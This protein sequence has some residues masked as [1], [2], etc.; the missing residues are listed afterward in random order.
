MKKFY[1]TPKQMC[2]LYIYISSKVNNIT[3]TG[4]WKNG[5]K[6]VIES[7][8][9]ITKIYWSFLYDKNNKCF[10]VSSSSPLVEKWVESVIR[11]KNIIGDNYKIEE[12]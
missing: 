6:A 11:K 9:G 2:K 4:L 10:R 7:V 12:E 1:I 8:D 3:K 5:F